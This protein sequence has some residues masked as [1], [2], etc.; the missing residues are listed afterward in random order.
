MC[1]NASKA[2]SSFWRRP[3]AKIAF[4]LVC[5]H[6]TAVA[7]YNLADGLHDLLHWWES[8]WHTHAHFQGHEL[9]HHLAT[10][11]WMPK[12]KPPQEPSSLP[13]PVNAIIILSIFCLFSIARFF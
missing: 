5:L 1:I 10:V 13:R 11:D 4:G 7:G 12:N 6:L 3:S 2:S 9:R 8:H